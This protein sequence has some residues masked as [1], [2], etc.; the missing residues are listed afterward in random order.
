MA[1]F[2][3]AHQLVDDLFTA[4]SA[5]PAKH[6]HLPGHPCVSLQNTRGVEETLNNEFYCQEL[7]RMAPHL[8]IMATS[9]SSN[10]NPLHRQLVKDREIIITEDPRLHLVWM[11]NRIFVKPLPR[12]LCSHE[13]WERFLD[14]SQDREDNHMDNVRKAAT[15]FLRTYRYLIRHESDFRIALEKHLVPEDAKWDRFCHFARALQNIEDSATTQRYAYGELRL[16]RLNLYAPMLLHKFN[17][18]QIHGQYGDIFGRLFGPILFIFALVTTLLNSMQVELTVEQLV[19]DQI[20]WEKFW[21]FCRWFAIIS[22]AATS[23]ITVGFAALWLWMFVDEWVYTLRRR[24]EKRRVARGI[25][26]Y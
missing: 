15:G 11:N 20:Q 25:P 26:M 12:Y 21:Y 16:T 2:S 1:P 23:I 14:T 6:V 9:C 4:N 10:I 17:Y 19:D 18:E 24:A 5:D 7:E 22:L 13:F 3:K 8:W